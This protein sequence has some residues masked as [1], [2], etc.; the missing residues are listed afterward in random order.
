MLLLVLNISEF[1]LEFCLYERFCM[2][3]Q[4]TNEWL[5]VCELLDRKIQDYYLH[6]KQKKKFRKKIVYHLLVYLVLVE[7]NLIEFSNKKSS[8]L[9]SCVFCTGYNFRGSVIQR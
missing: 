5:F 1:V 2:C 8:F 4:R 6:G 3:L 9:I 7:H